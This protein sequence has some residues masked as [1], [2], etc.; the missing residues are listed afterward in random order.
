MR[1][2]VKIGDPQKIINVYMV[3]IQLCSQFCL[4][5]WFLSLHASNRVRTWGRDFLHCTILPQLCCHQCYS[6]Q[7]GSWEASSLLTVRL[8][9]VVLWE[10]SCTQDSTGVQQLSHA[11]KLAHLGS[12]P[13]ERMK[14]IFGNDIVSSTLRGYSQFNSVASSG[15]G[16]QLI[17]LVQ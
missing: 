13:Q 10:Q 6:V 2:N 12:S 16:K 8:A 17:S 14:S 11:A 5:M 3:C 9:H 1:L 15:G 7:T 4:Q